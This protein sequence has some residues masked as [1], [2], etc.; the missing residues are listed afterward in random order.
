MIDLVGDDEQ[1]S[2]KEQALID[3]HEVKVVEITDHLQQLWPEPQI[4]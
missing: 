3:N 1:E 2:A 4:A